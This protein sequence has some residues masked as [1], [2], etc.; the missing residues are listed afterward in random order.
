[1]GLK[2]FISNGTSNSREVLF[3][4]SNGIDLSISHIERD[5][6]SG[7][8]L[9]IDTLLSGNRFIFVNLYAPTSGLRNDQSV[10]G[11]NI[12]KCPQ[13]YAGEN[14]IIGGDLNKDLDIGKTNSNLIKNPGYYKK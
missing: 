5:N 8:M 14:I 13:K 2:Y 12:L 9:I 10:F 1:M 6:T 3:L 7:R 4:V 11:N